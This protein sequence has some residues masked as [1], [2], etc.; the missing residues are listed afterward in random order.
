MVHVYFIA[1]DTSNF[2]IGFNA[3]GLVVLE[4]VIRSKKFLTHCHPKN[5]QARTISELKFNQ[6]Y[7]KL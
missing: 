6:S 5:N 3:A 7:F 4:S 2:L 1:D